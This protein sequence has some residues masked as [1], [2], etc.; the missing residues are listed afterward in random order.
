MDME[1]GVGQAGPVA[2]PV[3]Q[4]VIVFA[5]VGIAI[6]LDSKGPVFFRQDRIGIGNRVFRIWKFRSMKVAEQD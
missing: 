3:D 5:I 1:D 4:R 6:K 2:D